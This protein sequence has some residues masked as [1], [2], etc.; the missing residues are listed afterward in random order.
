M[1][2]ATHQYTSLSEHE[3]VSELAPILVV[4]I[5]DDSD[6]RVLFNITQPFQFAGCSALGFFV[7]G[8]IDTF[9]VKNKTDGNN[10]RPGVGVR[11]CEVSDRSGAD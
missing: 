10:V 6:L 1:L 11:G 8:R 4:A 5:D 2:G 7:N 3:N 9:A